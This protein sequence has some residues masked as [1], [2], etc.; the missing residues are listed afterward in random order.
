MAVKR[1]HSK[2]DSRDGSTYYERKIQKAGDRNVLALG[3]VLPRG[4]K[5]VRLR[6]TFADKRVLRIELERVG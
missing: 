1:D 6:K 3:P 2:L 4:W 5:V